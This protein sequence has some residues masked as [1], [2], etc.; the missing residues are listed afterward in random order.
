MKARREPSDSSGRSARATACS[1][2]PLDCPAALRR[3]PAAAIPVTTGRRVASWSSPLAPGSAA[4]RSS[5]LTSWPRPPLEIRTSR[6]VRWG[7]W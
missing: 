3:L 1:A 5:G 6:S 4:P 7:N 2:A